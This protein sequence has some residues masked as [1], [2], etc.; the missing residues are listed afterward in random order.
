[1]RI[2]E[3]IEYPDG[4]AKAIVADEN[5]NIVGFNEYSPESTPRPRLTVE[6]E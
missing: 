4:S 2:I 5:G 1:M 6:V 3:I